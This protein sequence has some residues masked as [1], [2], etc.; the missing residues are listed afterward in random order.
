MMLEHKQT[1][2]RTDALDFSSQR[3]SDLARDSVGD[4]RDALLRFQSKTNIDCVPCAGDQFRIN[5]MEVSA[6]GHT[7][8]CQNYAEIERWQTLQSATL[9]GNELSE[10][11]PESRRVR[12]YEESCFAAARFSPRTIAS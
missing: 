2:I 8:S 4:D 11:Q 9:S 3:G 10:C 1:V 6:I 7:E 5:R 12:D